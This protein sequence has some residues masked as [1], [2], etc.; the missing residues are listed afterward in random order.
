MTHRAGLYDTPRNRA[1]PE[2]KKAVNFHSFLIQNEDKESAGRESADGEATKRRAVVLKIFR[3]KKSKL[4]KA[5][6][7]KGIFHILHFKEIFKAVEQVANTLS[8]HFHK[9]VLLIGGADVP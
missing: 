1:A 7:L 4:R 8:A 2:R 3:S 6:I 9:F 5:K